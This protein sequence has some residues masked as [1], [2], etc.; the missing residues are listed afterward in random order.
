MQEKII[1][2]L[3][4]S[5]LRS[6]LRTLTG[7]MWMVIIIILMFLALTFF[8][9]N[10]LITKR[11]ERDYEIRET[12]N[13]INNMIGSIQANFE[14]YK[15]LSRLVMLDSN[16]TEFLRSDKVSPGLV[17]DCKVG[18]MRVLNVCNSIDSVYIL[19]NDG[20]Y[21]STGH[22]V[23]KMNFD[24][25]QTEE[26]QNVINDRRGGAVIA[27]NGNDALYRED[28]SPIITIARAIYDIN[29][30]EQVGILLMNISD[31]MMSRVAQS[32]SSNNVCI[33]TDDGMLLAGSEALS[34]RF[35]SFFTGEN[36]KYKETK[37]DSERVMVSGCSIEDMPFIIMCATQANDTDAV[38]KETMYVLLLL[39]ISFI[40]SVLVSGWFI[41][42]NINKPIRNLAQAME[43][44]KSAGWLKKID[45][46]MPHNEIG[47]LAD[48]YNR[49]IE[50]LNEL[51]NKLIE[52]EKT[53]QKAEMRV[54][55]EQ[56]KPHFLYNSL[57]TISFMAL[58]DGANDVHS[59]LET[60]GSFYR[61]FLSKGDREIP[62]QREVSIIQD[63]LSLQKLRYGDVIHDEYDI[64][65]DTRKLMIPKLILQPLVENCIYHGIRPKGEAGTIR[66]SSRLCDDGIHIIV[67]DDG[68]GMPQEQI[69]KVLSIEK[70]DKADGSDEKLSGFGLRGTIERIRYYCDSDD[71]VQIRSI[72]GELTEIE[73]TIPKMN[74]KKEAE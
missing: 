62:L 37:V 40:I 60:L 57:E 18:V 71:V 13:V 53:V 69:D 46:E 65:E 16:V 21:L 12:E 74:S 23:Y 64:A 45:V 58:N 72:P 15:D 54:L 22:G 51:F 35:D 41:M 28:G 26:W 70:N 19:R 34:E 32:Q 24:K 52:N 10:T 50:H 30:Q 7:M 11:A 3:S 6:K 47:M 2:R 42:R 27:M 9:S 17:Y 33:M 61:N 31:N 44:T 14:T 49:M 36:I 68:V 1:Q 8:I 29:S 63:Y 25:M 67:C 4:G 20:G 39:L 38:P 43:E 5:R 48:S 56:I 66:I 59:A 55:H 73:I